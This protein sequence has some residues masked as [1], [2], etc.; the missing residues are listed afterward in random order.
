MTTALALRFPLGRYHATPWGRN[1]N[2]G[3]V[4]WPPEPWRLLR[5]L[6]STWK[7]RAP[8]LDEDVIHPLL[9]QLAAYPSY[10]LPPTAIS[11]TRHYYPD[12]RSGTDKVFDGFVI[13]DPTTEVVVVYP[14]DLSP[15]QREALGHLCSL[16]PYLGR[17]ESICEARV[18][19]DDE[20]VGLDDLKL[21][22]P[23]TAGQNDALEHSIDLLAAEDPLDL[24]ALVMRTTDIR[25]GSRIDPPGTVR[26]R[27]PT[28]PA[29]A[30]ASA[31]KRSAA[32]VE[33]VRLALTSPAL[34]SRHMAVAIADAFRRAAM[35]RYGQMTDGGTSALLAGKDAAG[36][37]LSD[38][39]HAHYLAWPST[40]EDGDPR[41]IDTVLIWCPAGLGP[42]E[43][44]ALANIDQLRGRST[45]R[46]FTPCR[47]AIEGIGS[48]AQI[49][50]EISRPS[51]SW[52][53]FT[54]FA[55]PRHGR[56]NRPWEDHALSE[57]ERE[58]EVRGMTATSIEV[59]R[60]DWLDFRRYRLKER[61]A[62]TRRATGIRIE[63]D[64]PASGP[65]ALGSLSHFGLGLF[66]PE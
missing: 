66:R 29:P 28:P 32:P 18:V 35:A 42:N 44:A 50:P 7:C 1:T 6:Y 26:V 55:P 58:L 31:S 16:L 36:I 24:N 65:L 21:V 20:L 14:V 4:D 33:A 40:I 54:P 59:L 19:P 43:V 3:S 49:A 10:A 5:A 12:H 22:T 57:V 34:P 62:H 60:G 41:L 48:A 8:H 15:T 27:Y 64:H 53:S 47:V 51:R 45:V 9:G 61:L 46:D 17:A 23:L 11:H 52:V 25:K 13:V 2:E 39:R 56:K 63:F 37:P 30:P 38:H